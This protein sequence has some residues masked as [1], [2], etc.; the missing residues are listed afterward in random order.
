MSGGYDDDKIIVSKE[1]DQSHNSSTELDT[2]MIHYKK[3]S[4]EVQAE[5]IQGRLHV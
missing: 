2:K 1:Y 3:G 5:Q 4:E